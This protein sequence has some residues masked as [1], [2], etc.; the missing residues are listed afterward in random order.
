ME[1]APTGD[2]PELSE[3]ANL[4]GMGAPE[5]F[6]FRG[7]GGFGCSSWPLS[8]PL[9]IVGRE[10]STA[11]PRKFT[12]AQWRFCLGAELAHL[13]C[14][15]PVL[16]FDDGL[17]DSGKNAFKSFGKYAG[18]A[19]NIVDIVTLIPGVDQVAK[20]QK[21]IRMSRALSATHS[22]LDKA[23]EVATPAL[24]ALGLLQQDGK[25]ST[26]G[27]EGWAGAS[28][29]NRLHADRIA[30]LLCGD[31]VAAIVSMLKSSSTSL[32]LVDSL[33]KQGL[34]SLL[35]TDFP[36]DEVIRIGALYE[37]CAHLRPDTWTQP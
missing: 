9:L 33:H 24:K 21:L 19:S 13:R 30:L 5:A 25:P 26:A 22:T 35:T 20:L 32:P 12:S 11:G 27:R 1:A 34:L 4:L 2:V 6:W 18:T 36:P 28:L 10:H 37:Y 15:H 17:I 31:P 23:A 16:A 3:L 7:D 29:Q 14:Q 8:S